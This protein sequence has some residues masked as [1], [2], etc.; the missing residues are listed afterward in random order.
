MLAPLAA[1]TRRL[2]DRMRDRLGVESRFELVKRGEVP[3]FAY[4]AAR[5]LDAP[6]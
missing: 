4:K 5:V 2:V 6:R 3:R 1:L